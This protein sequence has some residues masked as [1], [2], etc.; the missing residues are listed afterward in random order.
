MHTNKSPIPDRLGLSRANCRQARNG[1]LIA[2]MLAFS[3][4]VGGLSPGNAVAAQLLAGVAKVD[5]T[6]TEARPVNDRL[7]VKALVL[8]N[9]SV[10][11]AIISNDT[12]TAWVSSAM[13]GVPYFGW[14]RPRAAGR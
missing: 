12:T 10:T 14:V 5:I 11:A 1:T 9:D 2:L 13:C 8:K 4:V 6:D 7:Y 3:T